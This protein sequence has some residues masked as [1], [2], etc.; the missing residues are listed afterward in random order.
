MKMKLLAVKHLSDCWAAKF[1]LTVS[2]DIAYAAYTKNYVL[3][4]TYCVICTIALY[5]VYVLSWQRCDGPLR[6]R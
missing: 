2:F 1:Q 5:F 6:S 4:S 3:S